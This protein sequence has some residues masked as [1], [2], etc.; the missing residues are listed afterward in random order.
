MWCLAE[1]RNEER[2]VDVAV[3]G[4]RQ[5]HKVYDGVDER[6]GQWSEGLDRKGSIAG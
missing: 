1:L 4:K 6:R 2:R 3:E 5:K